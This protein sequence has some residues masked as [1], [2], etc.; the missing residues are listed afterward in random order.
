[1]TIP[2]L[3]RWNVT[4]AEARE[5]QTSLR[6]RVVRRGTGMQVDLVAGVD[7]SFKEG[8]AVAAVVVLEYASQE[9]VE[10]CVARQAVRFPYVPGLL[11]F[12]EIP[13]ALAAWRKLTCAP[14]LVLVD[15]HGIA[16]PRRF[17]LGAHLGVLL[18]LPT[19]GCAKKRFIGAHDEPGLEAGATAQLLDGCEKIGV[20]VR[21][22]HHVKPVFVSI[23]HKVDLRGAV[24][25]VLRC[26]R[27][28]RLP[29][30][31]RLAHLAAAGS[32]PV[33]RASESRTAPTGSQG[34]LADK[35]R[36]L[37]QSGPRG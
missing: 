34:G 32:I 3:T 35:A 37:A 29:E 25:H 20:V 36:R 16:H 7:V 21:T 6:D 2:D 27:G 5:I 26:T 28:Y 18:D 19:V 13:P 22:K 14:D 15:G 33:Q 23:G 11:S 12:R 9:I 10:V 24:R 17:G 30:P 1:M 4:P 31:T 8:R